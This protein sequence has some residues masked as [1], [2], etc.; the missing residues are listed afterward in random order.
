MPLP[1]DK[2]ARR[3]LIHES[4]DAINERMTRLADE[5]AEE[6]KYV[7]PWCHETYYARSISQLYY[8][9]GCGGEQEDNIEF[10][11][12]DLFEKDLTL[13]LAELRKM[14]REGKD[15]RGDLG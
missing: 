6:V 9:P 12:E 8:C 3:A 5:K 7:C 2:K 15:G 1:T 4:F 14:R 11:D 13:V 10:E